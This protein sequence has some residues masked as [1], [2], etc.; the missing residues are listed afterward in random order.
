M[1]NNLQNP[2]SICLEEDCGGKKSCNCSTCSRRKECP[3]F[4]KPT[5]RITTKCT[6]SCSHCCF[7]CGPDGDRFMSL[8]VAEKTGEFIANNEIKVITVM[9]GEFFCHPKWKDVFKRLIVGRGLARVRLVTNGDWAFILT[10]DTLNALEPYKDILKVSV[11]KDRWHSNQY[12]DAACDALEKKGFLWNLPSEEESS[13]QGIIPV[14]RSMY[15]AN[16]FALFSCYCSDRNHK[17]G[18]LIDEDGEIYKCSVGRWEYANVSE[19][20]DGGFAER[21]KYFNKE[22]YSVFLSNCVNCSRS[23]YRTKSMSEEEKEELIK[24]SS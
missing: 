19:Y 16:F 21:F 18:F 14:G 15:S 6:Q 17:Y 24:K 23:Y 13:E 11:S 3:R 22:F 10:Q 2:C 5:I 1:S 20:T 12:V 8:G 7:S 4:L 9:G